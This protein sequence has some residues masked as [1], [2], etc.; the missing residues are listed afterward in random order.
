MTGRIDS[1]SLLPASEDGRPMPRCG[2]RSK[3]KSGHACDVSGSD[4]IVAFEA[5]RPFVRLRWCHFLPTGSG[6]KALRFD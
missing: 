3:S 4:P 5:R 6:P 2:M 1:E